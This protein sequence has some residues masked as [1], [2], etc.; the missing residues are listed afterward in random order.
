M[1]DHE[2]DE[3]WFDDSLL[4]FNPTAVVRAAVVDIV[5]RAA[6]LF[7]SLAIVFSWWWEPCCAVLRLFSWR[8]ALD[9]A[10]QGYDGVLKR[11]AFLADSKRFKDLCKMAFKTADIDN[12]GQ[13]D[14]TEI[15]LIVMVLHVKLGGIAR[16]TPPTRERVFELVEAADIDHSGKLDYAEFEVLAQV[17]AQSLSGR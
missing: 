6:L 11:A 4:K 5:E 12:S 15:Y 1:A 9:L 3:N 8:K 10:E 2:D 13:V 16:V 14:A 17:L 7:S